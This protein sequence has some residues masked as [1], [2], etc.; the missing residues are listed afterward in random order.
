MSSKEVL[1]P[2]SHLQEVP[3]DCLGN[4]K[5]AS[6]KIDKPLLASN[7]EV[8]QRPGLLRAPRGSTA[9]GKAACP[10]RAGAEQ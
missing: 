1:S 8:L 6:G 9:G 4:L 10:G 2:K 3:R 7:R 5:R